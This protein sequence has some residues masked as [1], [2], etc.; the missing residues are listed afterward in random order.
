MTATVPRASNS[1]PA[2]DRPAA[3]RPALGR[4]AAGRPARH[5]STGRTAT[6]RPPVWSPTNRWR[7]TRRKILLLLPLDVAFSIWYFTWLLSP[8]R[9]GNGLLYGLLVAAEVFNLV[10]AVGFWWTAA[11]A[12][13]PPAPPI[14][15]GLD[16]DVLIP[17]YN[18]AVE[19][20]EPTIAAARRLAGSAGVTV[21]V[22]DDGDRDEMAAVARR[23][24]A[25]YLRRPEHTGAKAGNLNHALRHTTSA[26]V[27]VFD[28]DH[29]PDRD[30]LQKT[31]GHFAD[32]RIAMVQTPQYYAN[33]GDNPVAG[34]AW[35]QQAL[36]FGIIARGKAATGSMFC[37]GTNVVFRR[38][39]L[40]SVGGLPE[41]SV[42]E[43]FAL[44]IELQERG[45]RTAYVPE[46]L[47]SGLGPEDMASYVSQQQRWARG[48]LGAIPR[49]VRSRLPVRRKLQYLLS[50]IFFLTGWTYLV[51]MALPAVRI[52]SGQQ[53]LAGATAS[54]FLAHFVPYFGFSM[55]TLAVAGQGSYTF[56]AFALM[57]ASF[58]THV[59][60]TVSTVLRRP[61]GFV[62]TPKVGAAG[63]QI[64]AVVP[65]LLALAVLLGAALD[66]L[67]NSRSPAT[68]NNVAFAGL[69]ICVLMVGIWPAIHGVRPAAARQADVRLER[70]AA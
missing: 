68:L 22:C 42:T 13:S 49:A 15:T 23:Y 10:Q 63:R 30:F 45:W 18:E 33:A 44:S 55:L 70:V 57:E 28:C 39:A 34:S 27:A 61:G 32:R 11:R 20:V 6:G 54:Q 66:G 43:D 3:E 47:A 25:R 53:A 67:Y 29:V 65:A 7:S 64:G 14:P 46:V 59:S 60:A 62:V 31:I 4:P 35:S 51:Y 17:V 24:G 48:C 41:D 1:G 69:H 26:L 36:F 8:Q 12:G 38:D 19:V 21:V 2:V 58:W 50:S 52:L 40:E 5:R 37:C 9:V 16:V 56:G